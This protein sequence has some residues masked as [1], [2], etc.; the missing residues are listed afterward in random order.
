VKTVSPDYPWLCPAA[1]AWLEVTLRPDWRVLETGAGGST[2]FFAK[3][4]LS[5]V[6]FEHD[7]AWASKVAG[8]LASRHLSNV[9]LHQDPAYPRDGITAVPRPFQF[10]FIDG[11]GRVKSAE[12][13]LPLIAPG[14]YLMLDDSDRERYQPIHKLLEGRPSIEFIDG[15]DRTTV[16][17]L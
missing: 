6:T 5:V 13:A 8:S 11:R 7:A 12:T 10:A 1:I 9:A 16:W 3:R 15:P 4:V 17:S 2:V 14:G